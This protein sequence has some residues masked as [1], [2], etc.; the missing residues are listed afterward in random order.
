MAVY[1]LASEL[2]AQSL[3]DFVDSKDDICVCPQHSAWSVW[4]FVHGCYG[5]RIVTPLFYFSR[6][7]SSL[8][9]V[10]E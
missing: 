2:T 4:E 6:G 10:V 5:A 8:F 1:V 7:H 9:N 3:L